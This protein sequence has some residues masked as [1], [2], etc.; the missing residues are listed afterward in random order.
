MSV[1][2]LAGKPAPRGLPS[3]SMHIRGVLTYSKYKAS[4][5][6]IGPAH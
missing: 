3:S 1:H 5:L 4:R 2:E 6:L